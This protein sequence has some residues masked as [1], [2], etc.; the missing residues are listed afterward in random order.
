MVDLDLTRNVVTDQSFGTAHARM[1]VA[2]SYLPTY[3]AHV[4]LESITLRASQV[5]LLY[6]I[7]YTQ[8]GMYVFYTEQN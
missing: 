8:Y 1:Y 6:Y 7:C 3:R 2:T 4:S 5:F